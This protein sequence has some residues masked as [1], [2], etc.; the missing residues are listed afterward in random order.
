[1]NTDSPQLRKDFQLLPASE[2]RV[3]FSSG[4]TLDISTAHHGGTHNQEGLDETNKQTNKQKNKNKQKK[5][6][7]K[8][9]KKKNPYFFIVLGWN[10]AWLFGFDF[11]T[12]VL[13]KFGLTTLPYWFFLLLMMLLLFFENER[14]NEIWLGREVGRIW[15]ELRNMKIQSKYPVG[16]I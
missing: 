12:F 11:C 7:T 9:N 3:V 6:K 5:T 1:M 14:G 10:V 2:G 13:V 4:L 15:K 16:K 8:Q